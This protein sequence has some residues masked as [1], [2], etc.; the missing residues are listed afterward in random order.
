[1]WGSRR[2]PQARHQLLRSS[3]TPPACVPPFPFPLLFIFIS[4]LPPHPPLPSFPPP[5]PCFDASRG[6]LT[7]VP[8]AGHVLPWTHADAVG[9]GICASLAGG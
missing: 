3:P 8:G 7:L 5:L 1:M 2:A 6:E 9:A 4:P